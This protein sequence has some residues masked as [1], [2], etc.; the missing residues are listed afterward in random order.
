MLALEYDVSRENQDTYWL[1]SHRR[2][3]QAQK[4][5]Q[6]RSETVPICTTVLADVD[7][8]Q[9]KRLKVVVDQDD[10]IRHEMT[11][12]KMYTHGSEVDDILAS[13]CLT[14][15]QC[16]WDFSASQSE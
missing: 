4:E 12:E 2:V 16:Q 15:S 6:F 14:I 1:M 11:H 3:S 13:V 9:S 5:G 8:P 7:D 10:G